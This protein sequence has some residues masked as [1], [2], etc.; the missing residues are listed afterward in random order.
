VV[1]IEL[2]TAACGRADFDEMKTRFR[3]RSGSFRRGWIRNQVQ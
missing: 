3:A 1:R 2:A